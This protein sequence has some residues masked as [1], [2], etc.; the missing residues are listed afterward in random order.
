MKDTHKNE[1]IIILIFSIL[2]KSA[3][4]MCSFL[5]YTVFIHSIIQSV[6]ILFLF[7]TV[8]YTILKQKEHPERCSF[9]NYFYTNFFAKTLIFSGFKH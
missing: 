2:L 3:Y 4:F 9:Q 8:Y 1:N 5:F 6:K 7:Y